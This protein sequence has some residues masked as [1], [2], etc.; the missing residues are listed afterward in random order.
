MSA[1][2]STCAASMNGCPPGANPKRES[3]T[4]LRSDPTGGVHRARSY[5]AGNALRA[6]HPDVVSLA[7]RHVQAGTVELQDGVADQRMDLAAVD[8]GS[9]DAGLREFIPPVLV[10]LVDEYVVVDPARDHVKLG[11]R[12]KSRGKLGVL[13][14]RRLGIA[15]ADRDVGW[16]G[17]LP[18]PGLVHAE[19][20]H[21]RGGHCEHG[22]D[23]FVVHV[24]RGGRVERQLVAQILRHHL[25]V[26]PAALEGEVLF[27]I[28]AR[29]ADP[30]RGEAA[31]RMAGDADPVR[32]D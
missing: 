13:L 20:L 26:A 19:G 31:L 5:T 2:W 18:Q 23:P 24:E 29:A 10:A 25:I 30:E 27:G 14:G 11:M 9:V 3:A 28:D 16:H 6:N 15:G 32:V 1:W 12:D 7:A 4:T 22:F 17:E 8:A 21:D